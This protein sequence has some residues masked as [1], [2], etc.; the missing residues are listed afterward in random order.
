MK[1]NKIFMIA[2]LL[3]TVLTACQKEMDVLPKEEI[4]Q[5]EQL[6]TLSVE[7]GDIT[8]A[9]TLDGS[10]LSST[11]AA[12]EKVNVFYGDTYLGTLTASTPADKKA[13]L[14]GTIKKV[15]GVEAGASLTML[16][17]G[18]DDHKWTYIGQD[19]SAPSAAG[20]MAKGYDYAKASLTVDAVDLEKK[21]ITATVSEAFTSQ[22][23]VYRFAFNVSSSPIAVKSFTLTSDQ[24]KLVRER[25]YEGGEWKSSHGS[26]TVSPT[27]DPAGN[28]YYMTLRNENTTVADT[29][30]FSVVGKA[31]NALYEGTKTISNVANLGQG[32]FLGMGV[33]ISKKA[34]AP[35]PP[36]T[37]TIDDSA[38]VL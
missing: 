16:F 4:P 8:K 21:E 18:R 6:W 3:G 9:M 10:K 17:P 36:A 23:S 11:W 12:G 31:D 20:T 37:G 32:K 15:A 38:E 30:T 7:V 34:F 13:T 1:Y 5:E 33:D 28:L 29:Y 27:A 19:G 22:Q 14:S 25:E 2:A 26:L 24:D 35:V